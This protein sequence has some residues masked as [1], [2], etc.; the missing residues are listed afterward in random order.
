PS[1][2]TPSPATPPP[3]TPPKPEA[4]IGALR[5][6][7]ERKG[8]GG[9]TVTRVEGLA[10]ELGGLIKEIKRALGCGVSE[11]EGC[12]I[13]QGDQREGLRRFFEQRARD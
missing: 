2:A 5:F 3:A 9:K 10:G 12:L 1:P 8:R 4:H 13:V 7:I 6:E 11:A